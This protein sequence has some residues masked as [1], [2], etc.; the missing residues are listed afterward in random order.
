MGKEVAETKEESK[1]RRQKR[2]YKNGTD[3][4]SAL[5]KKTESGGPWQKMLRMHLGINSLQI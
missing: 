5:W 2:K 3:I 1:R 4:K